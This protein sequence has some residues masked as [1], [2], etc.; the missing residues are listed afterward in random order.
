PP[1][2]PHVPA[3]A[4]YVEV[5]GEQVFCQPLRLDGVRFFG[6][7]LEAD[8]ATLRAACDR[9]LNHAGGRRE[10]HP[11]LPRVMLG[12]ADIRK[13]GCANPPD[14]NKGFMRE[15]DVA[16]WVPVVGGKRV[17]GIFIAE[18]VAW[19]LPYVFVNNAWASSSGREIYGFPKE[20]G[21]FSIPDGPDDKAVFS[22]DT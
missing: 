22:A 19:F 20:V 21:T 14:C 5:G 16:F 12:F 2:L 7:L 17:G 9:Y 11:L 10:Y 18:T 4:P 8:Y 6:F 15:I 1:A 3:L 13:I